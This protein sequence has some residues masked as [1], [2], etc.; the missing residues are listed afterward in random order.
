[1]FTE[2]SPWAFRDLFPFSLA[3]VLS[4]NSISRNRS[5]SLCLFHKHLLNTFSVYSVHKVTLFFC[6]VFYIFANWSNTFRW[7][8]FVARVLEAHRWLHLILCYT[9]CPNAR[10][11]RM[12][13]SLK[14][15]FD[16]KN[17]RL[18]VLLKST[19]YIVTKLK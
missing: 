4:C 15:R 14:Q 16:E 2:A 8:K 5:L 9:V 19:C 7:L 11:Q 3:K 6:N 13:L 12:L 10:E 17:M 18:L 1:M